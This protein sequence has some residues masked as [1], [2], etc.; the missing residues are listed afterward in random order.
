VESS[1]LPLFYAEPAKDQFTADQWMERFEMSRRAGQWNAAKTASYFYNS[2]RSFALKWYR[3]M[4]VT[5]VDTQDWEQVKTHF[6]RNYST[7]NTSKLIITDFNDLK[8]GKTESVQRFFSRVA[9]ILYNYKDKMPIND[10]MGPIPDTPEEF[11]EADAGWD[12]LPLAVQRRVQQRICRQNTALNIRYMG[13]Q[14]FAAGLHAEL[15]LEVIRTGTIDMNEA[16]DAAHKYETAVQNKDKAARATINELDAIIEDPDE[17][18]R[19]EIEA[20][21][22]N[23]QQRRMFN[24][25]NGSAYQNRN[26]NGG[27]NSGNGNNY[28]SGNGSNYSSGNGGS[29]NSTL[30]GAQPRRNNPAFGKTCHYCKK[31][32]HFQIDCHKRK[33]ENGEMVKVKELEDKDPQLESVFKSKN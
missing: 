26:S 8:Q 23:F 11:E 19:A 9:D 7:H 30:S 21:K 6:N 2:L 14:F 31:K 27:S 17:H 13:V 25:N 16:F 15:Q 20:L 29:S 10:L 24:A 32:N 12:A 4:E 3:G 22:R 5:G 1:K 28:S 33:R 18:E